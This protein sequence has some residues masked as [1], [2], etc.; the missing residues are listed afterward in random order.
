MEKI[1]QFLDNYSEGVPVNIHVEGASILYLAAGIIA[2][3]IVIILFK[4]LVG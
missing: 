1:N 3:G 2:S 4:K